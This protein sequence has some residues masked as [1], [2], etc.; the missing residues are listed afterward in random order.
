MFLRHAS[1]SSTYPGQ[2]GITENNRCTP[3]TFFWVFHSVSASEPSQSVEMTLWWPPWPRRSP[4]FPRRS[5]PSAR[6]SPPSLRRLPPSPSFF[7]PRH[8]W[9]KPGPNFS[10]RAY[11]AICV[12]SELLRACLKGGLQTCVTKIIQYWITQHELLSKMDS[13]R[14]FQLKCEIQ[15]LSLL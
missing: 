4:P 13:N 10:N 1:V 3:V 2:S 6:R 9:P 5:P 8:F 7:E 11:P 12:S 15:N 14:G